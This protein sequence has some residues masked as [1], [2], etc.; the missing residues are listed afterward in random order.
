[1][2]TVNPRG[3]ET[4]SA[5][6]AEDRLVGVSQTDGDISRSRSIERDRTGHPVRETDWK[7]N[8]TLTA[9]NAVYL[10]ATVTDPEGNATATEYYLTGQIKSVTDRRGNTT[11]YEIDVLGRTV[12][13]VD[14]LGYTV[15]TAYDKVGNV[16]S[17]TDKR[18]IVST[19]SYDPVYR[20]ETRK[21]AG[22]TIE[23]HV[24]DPNGNPTRFIDANGNE[25]TY[26]YNG[27]NLRTSTA[28]ADST[29]VS[30]ACDGVGN[31]VSFTDEEGKETVHAYDGENREISVAFAGETTS[32][33]YDGAGNLV[34][35]VRPKGNAKNM[36]YDPFDRMVSFEEAGLVTSYAY[37]SN[38]NMVAQTP[39]GSAKVE[40]E[41]DS[42][43]RNTRRER[44]G[45]ATTYD[46]DAEGNPVSVTDPEGRTTNYSYDKLNRRT[47]TT[48]PS[49]G[50]AWRETLRVR[51][52]YDGNDNVVRIVE[53]KTGGVVDTTE[54]V[55]DDFDRGTKTTRRGVEIEYDYDAN[56]NRTMV[57]SPN[58]TTRYDYDDRNR[59]SKA[60]S[61]ETDAL[62]PDPTAP[63]TLFSYTP[64]G[65]KDLVTYPNGTDTKY[66]YRPNNRIQS[67]EH[68]YGDTPISSFACQYDPN[69]NRV[70][71]TEFQNGETETTT[72][73][74]DAADRLAGYVLKDEADIATDSPGR[75]VSYTYE[76]Y[77]R[78]TETVEDDDVPVSAKTYLYDSTD[79]LVQVADSA[80]SS[81]ISY[82]YDRNG[83]TVRKSD[84]SLTDSDTV[85]AYDARDQLVEAVRGPEGAETLLGR[86]D[87]DHAGLRVRHLSS[88]RGDVE[89]YYDETAVLEER[90]A[91][92][93]SLL[94]RY[95]YADRLLSMYTGHETSFETGMQYYHH[96]PLGSTA[97]ITGF[98]GD[99]QV[100]Y[101]LDPWGR[102]RHRQGETVNRMVFTGQEHDE[103]TGL[104][105]FGA[106]YYIPEI[107]RFATRDPYLGDPGVPPSLHRYLYAYSN[108][109]VY[110]D[111][112][113]YYST[114]TE[115]D[116]AATKAAEEGGIWGTTKLAGLVG[117]QAGYKLADF[118]S[119][120]FIDRHDELRDRYDRGEISAL[121]YI[122]GSGWA[123][124]KSLSL[125]AATYASAGAAGVATEGMALT[126]QFAAAGAASGVGYQLAEDAWNGKLSD[127]GDYALMASAGAFL[128]YAAKQGGQLNEFLGN[129]GV[130]EGMAKLS[131]AASA[132]FSSLTQR[133]SEIVPRLTQEIANGAS[134]KAVKY[135]TAE[136]K[137]EGLGSFPGN[138]KLVP[139]TNAPKS[140]YTAR[141]NAE[142]LTIRAEG[143]ITGPHPN[144]P[145]GYRPE[146]V[147]GRDPGHHR[148]HLIPENMVD[149]PKIVNVKSNIISESAGSNL[150]P[151]R[152]FENLA[153]R[154]AKE[155]PNS[156]VKTVHFPKRQAG[157]TTPYAV[158][159]YITVDGK[160]FYGVTILNK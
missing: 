52:E 144:R 23:T 68:K 150:G 117:L 14:P 160:V 88:E 5:Y 105:Y 37:D 81:T 50:T 133:A 13:A 28:F 75:V 125:A 151:K 152:V 40:L 143:R 67:I 11:N 132:K 66:V 119:F 77:N 55:Y 73:S 124:A 153:G 2:K 107:A 56:G 15:E 129:S 12:L 100:S 149:E 83:N 46:Y 113:G 38:D 36:A 93:G 112:L 21:R 116:I 146:P 25:T 70:S 71:L 65:K 126:T 127:A 94:A 118:C 80:N 120:G 92:D 101:R 60:V 45:F 139:K 90:D 114:G 63:T 115:L 96:D 85:Y 136:V 31:L 111:L 109:T 7:G 22:T 155:N 104:V 156:V 131:R 123:G 79:R 145:K 1:M 39:P 138:I 32:R 64:D 154:I 159:H 4:A 9:Y 103:Q 24:Y 62:P 122:E 26:G 82:E 59:L 142:N 17:V 158:T 41:Y 8:A 108:P 78:K 95:T 97:N 137:V 16:V 91:S 110:I 61:L 33:E 44:A 47:G 147:G 128:G 18:G 35:V 43:N 30:Q 121:D 74:Y 27:R 10:P 57:S 20:P 106:R 102:I 86:Y 87:Y 58:G 72:Y 130:K 84:S 49:T 29:T 6:D 140:S 53:T 3:L 42:L 99:V 135:L 19:T 48:F 148:G 89:Y 34:K 76:G 157:Q 69:G 141:T 98:E 51:T 54:N 134:E